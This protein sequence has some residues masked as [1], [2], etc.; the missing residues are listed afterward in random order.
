MRVM[1]RNRLQE[2][3]LRLNL[4]QKEVS[5]RTGMQQPVLSLWEN[6]H[7]P[8][9]VRHAMRLAK[10]YGRT[11]EELFAFVEADEEDADARDS[12]TGTEA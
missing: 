3:R 11:V 4:K 1:P 8:M 6:G 10:C 2:H 12:L 9:A 7:V 5:E